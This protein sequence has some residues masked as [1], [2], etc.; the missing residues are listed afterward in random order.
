MCF[1]L[2]FLAIN[3][4]L[5]YKFSLTSLFMTFNLSFIT[6]YVSKTDIIINIE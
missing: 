3:Y 5:S 4:K 1:V 6:I 2:N